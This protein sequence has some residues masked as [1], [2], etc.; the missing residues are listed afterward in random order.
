[1]PFTESIV[2]DAT[3]NWFGELDYALLHGQEI[4][5]GEAQAE[6]TSFGEAFLPDRLRAA[7]RKL[8]PKVPSEALDDAYRKTTIPTGPNL[9]A[10]NRAFHRMLVDGIAVEC[11]RKDGSIGAEI[12]RL[13][14]FGDPEANDWLAVNQFTVIEGQHNRRPDV[15]I[16]LNGLPLG[17]I[18]LNNAADENADVW[19]AFAQLQTYKRQSDKRGKDL[20]LSQDEVAFYDAL[21]TND[22]AVQALGDKNLRFIAQELVKTIRENVTIDWTAK[23]SVRA[24]LRIMVKRVL[25]KFGYPPDKQEKA[26]QTVLQQAELLC[27]DWAG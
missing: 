12:V 24:K 20:G 9:I 7:L 25:R 22:S 27:A 3:L 10:Q 14:D 26:T 18:E 11:R 2:E 19:Q 1:M 8:N 13:I 17:V 6:R 4:A 21:E 5:P 23:E 15:V 16:F